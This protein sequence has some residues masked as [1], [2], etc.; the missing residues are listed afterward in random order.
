M[1]LLKE[2]LYSDKVMWWG[3][4]RLP[5]LLSDP[6][7]LQPTG[8][9]KIGCIGS[10]ELIVKQRIVWILIKRSDLEGDKDRINT[11]TWNCLQSLTRRVIEWF[12]YLLNSA[13]LMFFDWLYMVTF[14]KD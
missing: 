7:L 4:L 13:I 1:G 6:S 3:V 14:N 5:D 10:V 9:E 2:K 12:L 11:E 8:K